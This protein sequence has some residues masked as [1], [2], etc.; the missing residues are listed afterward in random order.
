MS[1]YYWNTSDNYEHSHRRFEW[2]VCNGMLV[3]M[4]I[5]ICPKLIGSIGAYFRKIDLR[6][7]LSIYIIGYGYSR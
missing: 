1:I 3:C 6:L 2:A 7:V 4:N 5:S